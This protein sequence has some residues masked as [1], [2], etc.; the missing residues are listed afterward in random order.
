MIHDNEVIDSVMIQNIQDFDCQSVR[1]NCDWVPNHVGLNSIG[2]HLGTFLKSADKIAVC[3]NTGELSIRIDNYC[4]T[5]STFVHRME[6]LEYR[7][8][9]GTL[10]HA[11]VPTHNV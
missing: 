2:H 10:G 3:E 6:Y 7:R 8:L 5:G 1:L 11:R 9:G 4:D